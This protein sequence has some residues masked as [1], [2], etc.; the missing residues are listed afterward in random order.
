MPRPRGGPSL[1]SPTRLARI[2]AIDCTRPAG[3]PRHN[4]GH[5]RKCRKPMSVELSPCST[6]RITVCTAKNVPYSETP[7]NVIEAPSKPFGHG[8]DTTLSRAGLAAGHFPP[9]DRESVENLSHH[10]FTGWPPVLAPCIK[11]R[12]G[13]FTNLPF[14]GKVD[15]T[16]V[17]CGRRSAADIAE[18]RQPSFNG[19]ADASPQ[20]TTKSP[21]I[22]CMERK[23]RACPREPLG[24]DH[25]PAR[26]R[27]PTA[28]SGRHGPP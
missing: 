8:R 17:G 26:L 16:Q 10:D 24:G 15:S 3:C 7:M 14:R 25:R 1:Y 2:F 23:A 28:P 11:T 4:F 18:S 13:A 27:N 12:A 6:S 5:C 22:R 21:A 9:F 19:G 20:I